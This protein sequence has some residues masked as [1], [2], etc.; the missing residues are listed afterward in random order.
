L[1]RH[2]Q[3][4]KGFTRELQNI[5]GPGRGNSTNGGPFGALNE[6]GARTGPGAGN[7]KKK[8][9]PRAVERGGAGNLAGVRRFRGPVGPVTNTRRN[10]EA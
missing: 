9:P 3:K 5:Q 1:Y 8:A 7:E 4:N 6:A 10:Q 2:T